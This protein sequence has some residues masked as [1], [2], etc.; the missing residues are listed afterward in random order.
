MA[1]AF[2]ISATE[3]PKWFRRARLDSEP[4]PGKDLSLVCAG[5]PPLWNDPVGVLP[6]ELQNAPAIEIVLDLSTQVKPNCV[7]ALPHGFQNLDRALDLFLRCNAADHHK[8]LFFLLPWDIWEL[9]P[10]GWVH[11][12]AQST[13]QY[14][15]IWC[16][17]PPGIGN[18]QIVPEH[19]PAGRASISGG[20]SQ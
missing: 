15:F 9:C 17:G 20:D 1:P 6:A 5:H 12:R 16:S 3:M 8:R 4:A 10:D 2:T 18:H 11:D 14:C 13:P 7:P 19:I